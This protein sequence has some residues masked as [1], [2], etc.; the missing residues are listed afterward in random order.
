MEN[1]NSL[2]AMIQQ[3]RA[4]LAQSPAFKQEN[5][6]EL[7]EHLRDSMARLQLQGLSEEEAFLVASRRIGAGQKLEAEFGKVNRTTVW[8]QR[9][10]WML[11]GLQLWYVANGFAGF[12][13]NAMGLSIFSVAK[14]F[15]LEDGSF[16]TG[17]GMVSWFVGF[18]ISFWLCWYVM[19]R[20]GDQIAKWMRPRTDSMAKLLFC[21]VAMLVVW[22]LSTGLNIGTVKLLLNYM[23]IQTYSKYQMGGSMAQ[24]FQAPLLL[25]LTFYVFNKRRNVARRKNA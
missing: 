22:V 12:G 6:D 3:W 2:D 13:R 23:P 16:L 9:A 1:T 10:F 21:F 15:G 14:Q 24:M 20:K 19:F 4:Q 11:V 7:E 18:A 8:M 25:L 17:V 5:V